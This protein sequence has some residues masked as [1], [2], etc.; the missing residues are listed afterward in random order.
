VGRRALI[1]ALA[2]FLVIVVGSIL[3]WVIVSSGTPTAAPDPEPTSSAATPSAAPTPSATPTVTPVPE[4]P[5]DPRPAA[6][7]QLA[8]QPEPHAVRLA[9]AAPADEDLAAVVVVRSAD[10]TPPADASAGTL[11]GTLPPTQDVFVDTSGGMPAGAQ[12][13]YGVFARD[14]AGSYSD[15]AVVTITVPA[16]LTVTPV[17]ITGTVTQLEGEGTLSDIGSIAFVAYHPVGTRVV[18]VI[19]ASGVA[20]A[21]TTTLTEPAGAAPG[22][23]AWTYIV[24]SAATRSLGEGAK[25]DEVFAVVLRDGNDSVSTAVTVSVLGINDP[26]TAS[27]LPGQ[28]AIAGEAFAFPI[29][30]GSFADPDTTDVLALSAGTLPAWLS[31]DPLTG[32]SG[33][34]AVADAGV[35]TV[36]VTATDPHGAAVSA[37]ADIEVVSAE[38]LPPVPVADEVTFDLGIDPLQTTADLLAN[39]ADPDAGPNALAALPASGDWLVNDEVAGTYTI[40][41]AGGLHLDSG[42]AADG[43]LQRLGAGMQVTGVIPYSVTDGADTVASEVTVTA[44]GA[45]LGDDEYG[46]LKSFVP[47]VPVPARAQHR[48]G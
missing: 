25:R 46:V 16:A 12:V 14:A 39:D 5:D 20:G 29:P 48:I 47:D 36:T 23:V 22:A 7:T 21:I 45:P 43:P 42:V 26:P 6:V 3:V 9:W 4:N 31:F 18:T 41:A 38:N 8:A 17:K 44:I 27:G 13:S 35:V 24:E 2:S 1:I 34:P 28:T 32:F 19:P 11:L 10:A 33:T 30:P 15:A 37:D 40:D